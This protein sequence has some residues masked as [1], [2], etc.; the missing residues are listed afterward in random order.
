MIPISDGGG[1]YLCDEIKKTPASE[2]TMVSHPIGATH[3][4]TASSVIVAHGGHTRILGAISTIIFRVM[5]Y[6]IFTLKG[7]DR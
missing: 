5:L 3:S 6:K 4:R 1:F 7:I 2:K